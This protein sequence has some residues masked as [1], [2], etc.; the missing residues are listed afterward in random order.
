MLEVQG[1]VITIPKGDGSGQISIDLGEIG[2]YEARLGEVA[3]VNKETAQELLAA[4]NQAWL[5]L[6]KNV[7]RLKF[8]RDQAENTHKRAKADAKLKCTD[9][10]IKAKGH[11]KASADLREAMTELDEDVIKAKDRLDLISITLDLFTGKMDAFANAFK[12][13]RELTLKSALPGQHYG[14]GNRPEPFGGYK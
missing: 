12:S 6:R 11:S 10:V 2:K 13:V 9:E 3:T 4:Y 5:K 14:D 1:F 8:E 7:G